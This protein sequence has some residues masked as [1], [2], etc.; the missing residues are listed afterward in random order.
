MSKFIPAVVVAAALVV[1]AISFAQTA[2][3][4]TRAQVRAELV[5]LEKAGY[6]PAENQVNYPEDLQAAEQRVNEQKLAQANTSGYGAPAAG[7]SAAGQA[8]QPAQVRP[9]Q[10]VFF[11][12]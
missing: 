4:L 9:Q 10:A 7:T 12:H 8:V 2:Q 5:Q 6:S 3:P 1:P 11:G